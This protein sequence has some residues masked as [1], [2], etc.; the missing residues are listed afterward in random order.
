MRMSKLAA[1]ASALALTA[2]GLFAGAASAAPAADPCGYFERGAD[3]LYNHCPHD[4][5]PVEVYIDNH[6]GSKRQTC[7]NTGTTRIGEAKVI[8]F[9]WSNRSACRV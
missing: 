2:T 9:A 7:V 3:A 8:A 4:E 5:W 6:D 1:A